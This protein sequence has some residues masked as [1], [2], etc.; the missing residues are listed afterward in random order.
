MRSPRKLK[1]A[2]AKDG[3]GYCK[4]L[5]DPEIMHPALL[6]DPKAKWHNPDAEHFEIELYPDHPWYLRTINAGRLVPAKKSKPPKS[7]TPDVAPDSEE[8]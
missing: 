4:I 5:K 8:K 7:K 3:D 6:C 2:P 1:F